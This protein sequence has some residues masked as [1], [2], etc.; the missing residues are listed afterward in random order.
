M[1]ESSGA[2]NFVHQA[3]VW[4]EKSKSLHHGNSRAYACV[5]A[6]ENDDF[7]VFF[8]SCDENGKYEDD[9][10]K[11]VRLSPSS[12]ID[13]FRHFVESDRK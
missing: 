3:C 12:I 1:I 9:Y 4:N 7:G 5:H 6:E 11:W 8:A 13:I 10:L 2:W